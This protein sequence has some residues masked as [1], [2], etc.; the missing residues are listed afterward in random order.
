MQANRGRHSPTN[1]DDFESDVPLQSDRGRASSRRTE[2]TVSDSECRTAV[3]DERSVASGGTEPHK[4][5]MEGFMVS[6]E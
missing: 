3:F 5:F 6:M 1:I 2:S 4:D